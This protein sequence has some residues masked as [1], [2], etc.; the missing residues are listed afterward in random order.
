VEGFLSIDQSAAPALVVDAAHS[1]RDVYAVLGAAADAAVQLQLSVNGAPYCQ[2]VFE[3]N[4]TISND[5]NGLSL[6]PL[7]AGDQITL[8]VQAVG[9]DYPGADLTVIIRL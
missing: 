6:A 2:L 1:V 5:A 9:Q 8:A 4:E 7:A 3:A